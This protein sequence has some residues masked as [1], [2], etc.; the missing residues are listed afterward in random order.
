MKRQIEPCKV[1]GCDGC[2]IVG[3]SRLSGTRR[4]QRMRCNKCNRSY[5]KRVVDDL[6]CKRSPR[7]MSD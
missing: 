2:V 4:I 3:S 5:G 7:S 6:F 1:D